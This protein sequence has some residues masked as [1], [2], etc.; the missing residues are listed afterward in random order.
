M[1]FFFEVVATANQ[2]VK[3]SAAFI[4]TA[5]FTQS[6][7]VVTAALTIRTLSGLLWATIVQAVVQCLILLWYLQHRFPGFLGRPDWKLMREQISYAVP[8]GVSSFAVLAQTS[9]HQFMVAN[10]FSAAEYAIYAAGC[11]Q[12]PLIGLLRESINSVMIPRV[13]YLQQQGQK[14][15]ITELVANAMRKLGFV[16]LPTYVFVTVTAAEFIAV[17]FTPRYAASKPIFLINLFAVLSAMFPWDAVN[18]AFAEQRFFLL[19]LRIVTTVLLI[20]GVYIGIELFGMPGAILAVIAIMF[21][22][23]IVVGYKIYHLLEMTWHD[24][25]LF[26]DLGK[27]AVASVLAGIGAEIVRRLLA[28]GRPAVILLLAAMVFCSIYG[29][30]IL[31]MRVPSSDEWR[32]V[33]DAVTG[34]RRVLKIA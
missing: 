7:A 28:G 13:S 9:F 20:P 3:Y 23:R 18:R 32:M 31:L 5:Q 34:F 8:L 17:L 2:D 10:R 33:R 11:S 26:S 6:V 1:G 16:Y 14:H 24:L 25:R 22:D 19:I 4:I 15:K 29:A 30:A 27:I 21:T 12:L